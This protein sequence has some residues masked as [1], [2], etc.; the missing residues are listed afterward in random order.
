MKFPQT[1]CKPGAYVEPVPV[2][3]L[4]RLQYNSAGLLQ[5]ILIGLEG[6]T[7]VSDEDK[8]KLAKHVPPTISL[9]G[10]TT[11]VEGVFYSN[12]IPYAPGDVETELVS[13][14]LANIDSL[15]FYA[16]HLT[17]N[18]SSFV[19]SLNIR[20]W[21]NMAGFN[22]LS[23]FIVPVAM[24]DRTFDML[25]SSG[26]YPFKMPYIAG[27]MV[28]EYEGTSFRY[29]PCHLSQAKVK[30]TD[31]HYDENG[32]LMSKITLYTNETF[33]LNYSDVVKFNIVPKSILLIDTSSGHAILDA[34]GAS[35]TAS[36]SNVVECPACKKR[37]VIPGAG[38]AECDD[39]H[40]ISHSYH[41]ICK[42]LAEF[43]LPEMSFERFNAVVASKD[44][45]TVT[46]VFELPEY[47][48]KEIHTTLS[49]LLRAIIP[50]SVCANLDLIRRLVKECHGSPET[51]LYY[52]NNP[53]RIETDLNIDGLQTQRL[54]AWLEDIYNISTIQDMLSIVQIEPEPL[55]VNGAPVL[56]NRVVAITG[57]FLCGPTDDVKAILEAYGA[58]VVPEI[59]NS[60]V[61]YL[62]T[63]GLHDMM[64][65]SLIHAA[66]EFEVPVVDE[67]EFFTH[68]QI[69]LD[70]LL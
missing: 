24:D 14:Y 10:G 28:Y 8:K 2:G 58:C 13:E 38:P 44:V 60:K 33:N 57:K 41:D 69:T 20:N 42:M 35:A 62:V 19:G 17:S 6:D 68:H 4:A 55:K 32:L 16:G 46:D 34:R 47:K 25:L 36:I 27:Y 23:G 29:A 64:D 49:S 12:D 21:L 66:R 30:S 39:P 63:G 59:K 51:L 45:W 9:Q 50:I 37:Y 5:K 22:V 3:L 56:R 11:W 43:E 1:L 67:V 18:A 7:A 26:R 40:C 48:G 31:I 61:D 52:A 54:V 15:T 70:N 65:G 53:L